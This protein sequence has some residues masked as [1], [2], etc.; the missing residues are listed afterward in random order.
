LLQYKSTGVTN[1]KLIWHE[2]QANS[3]LHLGLSIKG[4]RQIWYKWPPGSPKYFDQKA[5][6]LYVTSPSSFEHAI[7]YGLGVREQTEE[8]A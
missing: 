1:R 8:E 7:R 6:D 4:K 5:G 2:D 3:S